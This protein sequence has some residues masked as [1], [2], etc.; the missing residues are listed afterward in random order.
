MAVAPLPSPPFRVVP[1]TSPLRQLNQAGAKPKSKLQASWDDWSTNPSLF[2]A[3]GAPS[4]DRFFSDFFCLT[5]NPTFELAALAR[6]STEDLLGPYKASPS[7]R[8][9][10]LFAR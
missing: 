9:C 6:L 10:L 1:P 4:S 5:P 2:T 3:E 8:C 7:P